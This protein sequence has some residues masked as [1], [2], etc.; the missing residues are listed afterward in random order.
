MELKYYVSLIKQLGFPTRISNCLKRVEMDLLFDLLIADPEN[1]PRLE[2]FEDRYL[3]EI[4][5]KIGLFSCKYFHENEKE[6]KYY[7]AL[8]QEF[9][10]LAPRIYNF[11][12]KIKY[13]DI[14][15]FTHNF[16]KPSESRRFS[17]RVYRVYKRDLPTY[18]H[19]CLRLNSA[20]GM[21]KSA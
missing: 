11:L 21:L 7:V 17:E 1:L 5:R 9:R 20:K 2:D 8:I 15:R 19:F 13:E 14:I 16:Q 10:K 4:Y 12:Q 3:E 6:W 18:R